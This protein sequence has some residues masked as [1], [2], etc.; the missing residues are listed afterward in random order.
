[1]RE[2]G[3]HVW[4]QRTFA[5]ARVTPTRALELGLAEDRQHLH[6]HLLANLIHV[7]GRQCM[8]HALTVLGFIEVLLLDLLQPLEV[9]GLQARADVTEDV[10][11]LRWA[12]H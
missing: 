4:L 10:E 2:P 7:P 1:M 3:R 8:D 5:I 9:G 6:D 12:T 11:R